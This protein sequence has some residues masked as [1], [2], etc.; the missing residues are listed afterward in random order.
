MTNEPSSQK[1]RSIGAVVGLA[2]GDSLGAPI[3]FKRRDTHQHVSGYTAGGTRHLP[4]R[5]KPRLKPLSG[6]GAARWRVGSMTRF[7]AGP[8][9]YEKTRIDPAKGERLFCSEDE[10]RAA[11]WRGSSQ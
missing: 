10:A 8:S 5:T 7:G 4:W 9:R 3:Q 11:G 1:S 6:D 2:I